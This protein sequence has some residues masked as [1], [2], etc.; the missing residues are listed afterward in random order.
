MIT[1]VNPKRLAM[2]ERLS[3]NITTCNPKEQSLT[4]VMQ[5]L[6]MT[7]GFD[8][9]LE[10]SGSQE[11][12]HQMIDNMLHGGHIAM[13]GLP[14]TD[15][16]VP[17]DQIILKGLFLKGIYGR[18]MFETWYKMSSLLQSGLDLKPLI[19]H[20]F[21]IEDYQKGF[22]VMNSGEAGKVILNWD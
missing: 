19:T 8:V 6:G 10:M 7:E 1:D 13:L 17:L 20:R 22:D 11:A 18:E 3:Y 4:D 15:V 2:V 5:G 12:L 14:S 9:G 16:T 21:E